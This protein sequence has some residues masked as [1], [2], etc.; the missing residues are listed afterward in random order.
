MVKSPAPR[1]EPRILGFDTSAMRVSLA[2][3]EG[4]RCLSEQLGSGKPD[5]CLFDC[6]DAALAEAGLGLKDLD[7]IGV[8]LGP[9]VFTGT[10]VGLATAK[11][12]HL[13]SG[14]SIVGVPVS[15]AVRHVPDATRAGGVIPVPSVG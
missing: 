7:G 2:L 13:T 1:P 11:A 12:L 6:V 14:I 15:H 10:R 3:V 8:G 9:G 5:E 4:Q